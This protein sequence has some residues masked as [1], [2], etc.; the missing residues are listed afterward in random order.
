MLDAR[1]SIAELA[2]VAPGDVDAMA[3]V[4]ASAMSAGRYALA[5]KV[6]TGLVALE[7]ADARHRLRLAFAHH[8]AGDVRMAL[9]A[10]DGAL[11]GAL[12]DDA[13]IHALLLR[14]E[15]RA[16]FDKDGARADLATARDLAAR[17]PAAKRVLDGGA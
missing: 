7:P 13:R 8:A 10:L 5:V 16:A 14:A 2:G 17:S 9:A 3:Q 11:E 15:I 4:G 1:A 6:F 12:D